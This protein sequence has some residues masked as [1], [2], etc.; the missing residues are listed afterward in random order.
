MK[1]DGWVLT[2]FANMRKWNLR[3]A[4]G[5]PQSQAREL[6][7]PPQNRNEGELKQETIKVCYILSIPCSQPP[8]PPPL[9]K[10]TNLLEVCALKRKMKGSLPRGPGA[11]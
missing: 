2:D 5:N 10:Q 4:M 1:A 8:P 7:K 3:L 6:T 9:P 11:R